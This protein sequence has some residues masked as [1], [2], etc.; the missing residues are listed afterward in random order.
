MST[1][2]KEELNTEGEDV[3]EPLYGENDIK[4]HDIEEII[5]K[6]EN[7]YGI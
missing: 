2:V 3:S 1:I 7:N 4:Y 5:L 6:Q